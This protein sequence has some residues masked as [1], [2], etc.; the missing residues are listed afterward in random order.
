MKI[1]AATNGIQ[2]RLVFSASIIAPITNIELLQTNAEVI[3]KGLRP[4]LSMRR[5]TTKV[6]MSLVKPT[7]T[8]HVKGSHV[9]PAF[10]KKYAEYM[11]TNIPPPISFKN[12]ILETRNRGLKFDPSFKAFN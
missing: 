12:M 10:A 7:S 3:S 2:E 11:K 4:I 6:K 1:R 8:V 9:T 5:A